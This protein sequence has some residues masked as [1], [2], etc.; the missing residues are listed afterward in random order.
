MKHF[1]FFFPACDCKAAWPDFE[2]LLTF[3]D[4]YRDYAFDY[5]AAGGT[6]PPNADTSD[7]TKS[8]IR[9]LGRLLADQTNTAPPK[10]LQLVQ[11]FVQL[12]VNE[13]TS[14][15]S[16]N[17][18]CLLEIACQIEQIEFTYNAAQT[19]AQLR[20]IKPH[21][22]INLVETS[23][24]EHENTQR[25][26]NIHSLTVLD[27]YDDRIVLM[28][29]IP[30]DANN[31][32]LAPFATDEWLIVPPGARKS[33]HSRWIKSQ[34]NLAYNALRAA[35]EITIIGYSLP[36]FDVRSRLLFRLANVRRT[37]PKINIID[38]V[39]CPIANRLSTLGYDRID[40]I[41]CTWQDW[42][43]KRE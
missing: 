17:W 7:L 9:G 12:V 10:S 38:P 37:S 23:K 22:S 43:V 26:S 29:E 1:K 4:E 40:C 19:P 33:F 42:I 35:T 30:K 18:D 2:Q 31:R 13:P 14:V 34:W 41:A 8:L 5:H 16:F 21:G 32:T 24:S 36:E 27:D 6:V 11:D 25:P 20:I 3:I 39:P 28:A 15:I